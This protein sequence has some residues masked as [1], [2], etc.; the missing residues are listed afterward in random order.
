MKPLSATELRIG[1]FANY[2]FFNPNPKNMAFEFEQVEIVGVLK[3]TFYFKQKNDKRTIKTSELYPIPLTEEWL[4]R[5][6]FSVRESSTSKQYYIGMNEITHDWLFD[7][8]WLD[9]PELIKAPNAPFYR[10]GRHTIYYVHTLQNL[11][12]S[13]CGEELTLKY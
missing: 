1:N 3:N 12:F 8:I 6:G 9:R 5:F 7:L 4:V 11:F 10:N 13:L 2:R